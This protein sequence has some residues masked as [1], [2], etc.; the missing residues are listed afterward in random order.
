MPPSSR[1]L[2]TEPGTLMRPKPNPASACSQRSR[3]GP[4]AW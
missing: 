2:S 1:S 3:T 4:C